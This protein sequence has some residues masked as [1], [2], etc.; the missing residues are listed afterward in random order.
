MR[1]R[2]ISALAAS[3]CGGEHAV[4]NGTEAHF[5]ENAQIIIEGILDYYTTLNKCNP[6]VMNL[7][8]L[9]DWWLNVVCD[10]KSKELDGMRDGSSKA[11]A[12]F[13]QLA[14]AGKD[15]AG[16]MKTT[17]YR[18]LQ[19][20]R[21]S[22]IRKSFL[23]D[24]ISIED[25]ASGSCDIYVVLPE[26]MVKT[27]S[28]MVRMLMALIKVQIIQAEP[29]QLKDD[30]CFV[31]DELGQF[32]YCP[33]V[34]QVIATLRAR[35]VKVWASFTTVGQIDV[36]QDE[37]TFRGMPVKHFMGSDDIKTLDWIQKL[38]SKTTVLTEHVSKSVS[39][40][41]KSAGSN[42]SNNYSI[43]E[44]ATDLIHFNHVREMSEDEQ[45]VFIKGM[46]PICCKK[47]YYYKE[48][49]Y[50]GRFNSNPIEERNKK[51]EEEK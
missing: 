12:A 21:S 8:A 5:M 24:E 20:L 11:Q 22:N 2:Y 34:E 13:A 43:A 1:D 51:G 39:N 26:D 15:E 32:G 49:I 38:G 44:T 10:A 14:V 29:S 28:R 41:S 37:A 40:A 47:T 36:Y 17:I 31:L 45:F 48:P 3:I 9:H 19:W 7:V 46:R 18:Q 35:G 4:K 23:G 16:S 30:Y 42:V 27:Y 6:D 25:F 50:Q 33:D